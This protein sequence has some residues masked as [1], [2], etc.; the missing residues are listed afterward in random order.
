MLCGKASVMAMRIIQMGSHQEYDSN[1]NIIYI[2]IYEIGYA[3]MIYI[4][5][6]YIYE[7]RYIPYTIYRGG[8]LAELVRAWSK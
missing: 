2:S 6:I 5:Y 4:I 3:Y 7:I 1:I 8:E